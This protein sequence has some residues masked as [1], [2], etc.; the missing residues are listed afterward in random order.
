MLNDLQRRERELKGRAEALAAAGDWPASARLAGE[1][2]LLYGELEAESLH[3]AE[4]H[5]HWGRLRRTW[6]SFER[7]FRQLAERKA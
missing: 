3:D 4:L 7:R 5:E 1:L 2:A 6:A